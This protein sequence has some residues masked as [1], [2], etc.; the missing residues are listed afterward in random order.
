VSVVDY[1]RVVV[2]FLYFVLSRRMMGISRLDSAMGIL[3]ILLQGIG[4]IP[5]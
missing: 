2:S 4:T 1:Y 5:K 3:E